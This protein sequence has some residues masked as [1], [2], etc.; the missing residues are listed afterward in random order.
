MIKITPRALKP[1][2]QSH[3]H[4]ISTV[5]FRTFFP[6]N[7]GQAYCVPCPSVAVLLSV[8]DGLYYNHWLWIILDINAQIRLKYI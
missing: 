7:F 5:G 6:E 4:P 8:L 1:G 2:V 3:F